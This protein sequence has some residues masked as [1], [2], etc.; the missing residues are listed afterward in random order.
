MAEFK[1]EQ[2]IVAKFKVALES[3]A[4]GYETVNKGTKAMAQK[5]ITIIQQRTARGLDVDGKPFVK[6][7]PAYEKRKRA[8]LSGRT[9]TGKK[10]KKIGGGLFWKATKYP[11]FLRLTGELFDDMSYEFKPQTKFVG[12]NLTMKWRIFIKDRSAPKAHGLEKKRKFFAIRLLKEKNEIIS[13]FKAA[14]RLRGT[15]GIS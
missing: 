2:E 10:T 7:V 6:H 3:K 11:D 8:M 13:A 9:K 5:S 12:N 1:V 4:F 14:T 15:G